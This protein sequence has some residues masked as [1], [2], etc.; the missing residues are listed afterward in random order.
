MNRINLNVIIV[1]IT[2][3]V[4]IFVYYW[5]STADLREI[6]IY[7]AKSIEPRKEEMVSNYEKCQPLTEKEINE[8][9]REKDINC[10]DET[11]DINLDC[12]FPLKIIPDWCSSSNSNITNYLRLD[13]LSPEEFKSINDKYYSVRYSKCIMNEQEDQK[14][15]R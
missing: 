7:C 9:Y 3:L 14:S 10:E 13:N 15:N 12:F 8:I 2:A 11:E 1:C 5:T 6:K 4:V